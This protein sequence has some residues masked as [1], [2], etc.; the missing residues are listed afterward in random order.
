M[1]VVRQ[2]D[3]KKV[4]SWPATNLDAAFCFSSR[5]RETCGLQQVFAIQVS[6]QVSGSHSWHQ[7]T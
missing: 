5:L 6:G 3:M 7:L 1:V 2:L 4:D